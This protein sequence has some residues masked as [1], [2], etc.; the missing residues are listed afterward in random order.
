MVQPYNLCPISVAQMMTSSELPVSAIYK[1]PSKTGAYTRGGGGAQGASAP[2]PT[3]E[4]SSAQK[5]S[6]EER[7]F[8]PDMSA[9]ENV[10]VPLRYDKINTKTVGKKR[11][12]KAT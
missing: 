7:K 8:H 12:Y 4:K 9:K 5:C 1:L 3:L 2:P 11:R 6:K 10:H